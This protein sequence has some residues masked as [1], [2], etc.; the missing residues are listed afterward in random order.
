M[1][2]MLRDWSS[3]RLLRPIRH[4][5]IRVPP[6][7]KPGSKKLSWPRRSLRP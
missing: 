5:W 7:N 2:S 1:L 6:R 3:S 4:L